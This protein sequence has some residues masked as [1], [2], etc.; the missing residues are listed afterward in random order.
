[1]NTSAKKPNNFFMFYYREL[2]NTFPFITAANKYRIIAQISQRPN[3]KDKQ[4]QKLWRKKIFI[5]I[6]VLIK[7]SL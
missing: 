3:Y 7:C 2:G 6:I 1:M 4:K 5:Q